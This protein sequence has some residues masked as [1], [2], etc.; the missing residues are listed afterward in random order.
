VKSMLGHV[1]SIC[2]I[3]TALPRVNV[4]DESIGLLISNSSHITSNAHLIR[5]SLQLFSNAPNPLPIYH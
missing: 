3:A 5:L 4:L 2:A 1:V